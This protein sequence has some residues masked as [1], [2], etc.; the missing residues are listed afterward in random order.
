[1]LKWALTGA[2]AS[3]VTATGNAKHDLKAVYETGKETVTGK[4]DR[5]NNIYDLEGNVG[6]W[7]AEAS[8]KDNREDRDY[9]GGTYYRNNT[10]SERGLMFSIGSGGD[11]GSRSAL[12]VK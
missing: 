9:R 1:M 6:E 7:T 12:Y 10:P 4:A 3:K 8:N 5:I 2:D 11:V